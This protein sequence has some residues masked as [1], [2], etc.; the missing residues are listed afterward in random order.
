MTGCHAA[1]GDNKGQPVQEMT[2][3]LKLLTM[4]LMAAGS[5]IAPAA[6]EAAAPDWGSVPGTTLVLFYPGASPIEWI[7]KGSE[8]GGA[9][10][11]RKG[12]TCRDCHEDE[13]ADM[14]TKMASGQKLEPSPI[15][16]KAGSIPVTMQAAHDG[17]Q[18]YMR[19]SWKQPGGSGGE[20]MDADNKVKLAMMIDGGKVEGAELSGC[21][22]ACH[23]DARSMPGAG[24]DKTKYLAGAN[25]ADGVFYDLI[26]WTSSGATH[27]G[28]VGE[29]RV[30][31]GGKGL[32]EASGVL[33]GDTWTVTFV[34]KLASA[35]PGD[36]TMA[37]GKRY[38]FGIAIHDQHSNG[39]FHHVSMGYQLGIDSKADV[40]ANKQ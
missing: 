33:D 30:M 26:Q 6:A 40:T 18:L 9:R 23:G 3:K 13:L 14:G 24:A 4:A 5:C 1:R 11:L 10:G 8:H 39:R 7:H 31:D 12:D 20:K 28:H 15:A 19:F 25:L 34:R 32:V 35:A 27:D 22:Q 38:S 2:M 36:V 16:G 29:K 37:S 17:E 21:W